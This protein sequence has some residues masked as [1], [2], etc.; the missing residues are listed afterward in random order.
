MSAMDA[1]IGLPR[2]KMRL[3]SSALS[4]GRTSPLMQAFA[5]VSVQSAYSAVCESISEA[6]ERA[7]LSRQVLLVS[8][9]TMTLSWGTELLPKN[10]RPD[11][12][13]AGSVI[14][15]FIAFGSL[16]FCGAPLRPNP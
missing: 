5:G 1:M 10:P 15:S 7:H 14:P 12:T 6:T 3:L 4:R 8:T 13:F 2:T 16:F 11:F 9:A